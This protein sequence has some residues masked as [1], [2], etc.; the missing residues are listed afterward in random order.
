MWFLSRAQVPFM[1]CIR[2]LCAFVNNAWHIKASTAATQNETVSCE[3]DQGTGVTQVKSGV[4]A[5]SI[6]KVH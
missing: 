3:T 5:R 4:H 6:T 1:V 2:S